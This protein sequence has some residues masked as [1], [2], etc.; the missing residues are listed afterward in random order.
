VQVPAAVNELTQLGF[1]E[2]SN[3]QIDA[4][5]ALDKLEK[6]EELY[7]NDN[8]LREISVHS[9]QSCSYIYI[10]IHLYVTYLY[11]M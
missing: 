9:H 11:T 5:P 7:V 4:V 2:L 8:Q 3:N 6:L 1:L 10:S